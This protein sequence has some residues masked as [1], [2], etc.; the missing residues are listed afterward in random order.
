MQTNDVPLTTA[1][2]PS[3]IVC[4]LP[5]ESLPLDLY[6]PADGLKVFL[7][8]FE[9][10]LDLLLYLIQHQNLDIFDIP[11]AEITYQ[12]VQYVELMKEFRLDLAAEY[13]VMAAEL[14]EIKS[15]L[16]LPT[17]PNAEATEPDPRTRLVRQLREYARYKKAAQDLAMLP[18]VGRE[19]FP[20][21]VAI[22]D[23]PR[24]IQTPKINLQVLLYIMQGVIERARLFSSHRVIREPLSVRER[25]SLVLNALK[26]ESIVEFKK[27]FTLDEGR[28][29]AVV[30]LLAIL[31]LCKES[32][33]KIAQEQTFDTISVT[34][35]GHSEP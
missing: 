15:Q 19:V 3:A 21:V 4:G 11:I 9:G 5:L 24:E 34:P 18:Q 16:L 6:V 27:L 33:I 13:M 12:Y 35:I 17:P 10:P 29:G 28:A 26:T 1:S 22:P 25:M 31:E 2:S 7:A 14:T 20:I 30:A 8:T 32:L 23:V